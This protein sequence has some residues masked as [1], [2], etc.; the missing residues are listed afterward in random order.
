MSARDTVRAMR[1]GGS[2]SAAPPPSP[3]WIKTALF[4]VAM[5]VVGGVSYFGLTVFLRPATV[6]ASVSALPATVDASFG[7]VAA[8]AAQPA[9][10]LKKYRPVAWADADRDK[11]VALDISVGK[12]A[13]AKVRDFGSDGPNF[14]TRLEYVAGDTADLGCRATTKPGHLCD[15]KGRDD[16]VWMA[17]AEVSAYA[18]LLK[19]N[20]FSDETLQEYR[21]A[22]PALANMKVEALKSMLGGIVDKGKTAHL[23]AIAT[24]KKVL[25]SGLVPRDDFFPGNSPLH[26]GEMDAALNGIQPGPDNCLAS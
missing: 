3:A 12:T 18:D 10:A 6:T 20:D 17:I 14:A 4:V 24:L 2:F 21:E 5:L 13:R 9:P 1:E 19:L 15:A 26:D 8:S 23:Q 22:Y 7:N 25:E 16:F 11:C